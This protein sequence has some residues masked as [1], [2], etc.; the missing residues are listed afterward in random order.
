MIDKLDNNMMLFMPVHKMGVKYLSRQQLEAVFPD[1]ESLKDKIEV[2]REFVQEFWCSERTLE[3]EIVNKLNDQYDIMFDNVY[4][5]LGERG[6]GKTSVIYT[7]KK[8]LELDKTNI[9]LPIIMSELIPESCEVI[10]WILSLMEKMV[11]DIQKELNNLKKNCDDYWTECTS[12]RNK[13]SLIS[14]F[15]T[16][17][18][19]GFSKNYEEKNAESF[20]AAVIGS[21]R[22]A[23]NSFDF[24]N[25]LTV[26][27]TNLKNAV[28]KVKNMEEEPLIYIIFDDVDLVPGKIWELLS[29]IVKYLSHPNVIVLL[30]ADEEMLYEVVRNILAKK[31]KSKSNYSQI[32]K[33]NYQLTEDWLQDTTHLYIDK[34]LPQATRY[35]IESFDTCEKRGSFQIQYS[36]DDSLR[37]NS[38]KLKTLRE[39]LAD[40]VKEYASDVNDNSAVNNKK[41]LYHKKDF[42]DVYFLFWGSTSRQLENERLLVEE[43]F[44]NLKR[45]RGMRDEKSY[46]ARLYHAVYAFIFSTLHINSMF[47]DLD[48]KEWTNNLCKYRPQDWGVYINYVYLQEK[49]PYIYETE[50]DSEDVSEQSERINKIISTVKKY[51]AIYILLFFVENILLIESACHQTR[52]WKSRS[53]VHGKLYLIEMLDMITHDNFSL[54]CSSD[55]GDYMENFLYVYKNILENPEI[56]LKFDMKNVKAIKEYCYALP[57]QTDISNIRDKCLSYYMRK[58]PKWF[59]TFV[60]LLYMAEHK[61]YNLTP[62]VMKEL[63]IRREQRLHDEVLGLLEQ[64]MISDIAKSISENSTD[65]NLSMS[66]KTININDIENFDIKGLYDAV[67]IM[68]KNEC[69]LTMEKLDKDM[70]SKIKLLFDNKKYVDLLE[71]MKGTIDELYGKFEN[72]YIKNPDQCVESIRRSQPITN[73][74]FDFT[75]IKDN[76]VPIMYMNSYLNALVRQSYEVKEDLLDDYVFESGSYYLRQSQLQ[77]HY[78]YIRDCLIVN[79][80]SLGD[81]KNMLKLLV[82]RKLYN[83][84]SEQYIQVKREIEE[85]RD[86]KLV[87]INKIPYKNFRRKINE[88][89][90]KK[91]TELTYVDKLVKGYIKECVSSYIEYIYNRRLE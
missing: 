86:F 51:T 31:M 69:L 9:V 63:E 5:I 65:I 88:I 1:F 74:N 35:Y 45:L 75:L 85:K 54:V 22:S 25:R 6:S 83:C 56:L 58:N 64:D 59:E 36:K 7:V 19:L 26:F 70:H 4:S 81:K 24:S 91:D 17:K 13:E 68:E 14:E 55:A 3:K 82:L 48:A 12:N 30:T 76:K 73:L 79:L 39:L 42:L 57:R 60:K 61:I 67:K 41:F 72:Y 15:E 33:N 44:S 27:W 23:Q 77:Y 78:H 11:K 53:K 71:E 80:D 46:I 47:H 40:T 2:H 66:E 16:V 50:I 29:T 10:E 18:E 38:E 62:S 52:S 20:S 37:N 43:F 87:D 89:L 32:I 84:V 28:K 34:I 49:F 90:E 8:H 21:E